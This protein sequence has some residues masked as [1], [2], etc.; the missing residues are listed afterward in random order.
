MNSGVETHTFTGQERDQITGLYYMGARYYDPVYG[1]FTQP[2][3]AFDFDPTN[4]ASFNLYA[5][6][7][8]NPVNYIDPSGMILETPWDVANVA[9]GAAMLGANM[10]SG[11]FGGAALDAIGLAYDI[12]ATAVPGLPA[13]ASA[14]IKGIRVGKALSKV[15]RTSARVKKLKKGIDKATDVVKREARRHQKRTRGGRGRIQTAED[16]LDQSSDIRQA[17][18]FKRKQGRSK[19]IEFT[20][21]SDQRALNSLNK[22]IRSSKDVIEEFDLID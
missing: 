16:A 9:I 4:P 5:Y 18:F 1:R 2:D 6:A 14:A 15:Q 13:G 17:Q 19:D 20:N 21:K 22:R 12:F 7:R 3:P 11:N 10:A 8:G